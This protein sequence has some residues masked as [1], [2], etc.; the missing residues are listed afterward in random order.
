MPDQTHCSVLKVHASHPSTQICWISD[1]LVLCVGTNENIPPLEAHSSA[2][3]MSR[4]S[5]VDQSV[6]WNILRA[7][8]FESFNSSLN[9]L[10]HYFK[11]LCIIFS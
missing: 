3:Q 4:Q 1:N 8:A 10:N 5:V 9:F 2:A 6:C 7:D 11:L